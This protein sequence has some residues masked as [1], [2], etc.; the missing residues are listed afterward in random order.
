VLVGSGRKFLAPMLPLQYQDPPPTRPRESFGRKILA[1]GDA[2]RPFVLK[3]VHCLLSARLISK[4][5]Q[6]TPDLQFLSCSRY[7]VGTF[8]KSM[9]KTVV[10]K[11]AVI[12]NCTAD[13]TLLPQLKVNITADPRTLDSTY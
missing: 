3:S 11:W 5:L 1:G 12:G 4:L 8:L 9:E 2:D 10:T 7:H 6:H 13:P